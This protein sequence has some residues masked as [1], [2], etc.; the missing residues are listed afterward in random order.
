[1]VVSGE[2][3]HFC[4]GLTCPSWSERTVAEGVLHSRMWHAALDAIQFGRCRWWRRCTARPSGGG[5]G[6]GA[7]ATSGVAEQRHLRPA[8]GQ[9]ASSSA[10]VA[11]C[12]SRG[13]DRRGPHDRHDAHRPRARRN[14]GERRPVAVR[15]RPRQAL[16][17]RLALAPGSPAT[18]RC[19]TS[20]SSRRCRASPK[21]S[22]RRRPVRRVADGRHRAGRPGKERMR[23]FL[24]GRAGKVE[25]KAMR[26][27]PPHTACASRRRRSPMTTA[28]YR[29]VA[30]GTVLVA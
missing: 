19:P 18:R 17:G 24:G 6:A 20:R 3:Q 8:E 29:R 10:A 23:A 1:M 21:S 5:L 14:E 11:R 28:R 30:G 12:A 26:R 13:S 22:Q 15:G 7:A 16:D 4:A 9:R 27:P 25:K 2:G